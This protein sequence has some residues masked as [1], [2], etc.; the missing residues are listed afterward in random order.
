MSTSQITSA[1]I[2]IT[3]PNMTKNPSSRSKGHRWEVVIETLRFSI[4]DL[5][6]FTVVVA[7]AITV[8][9]LIQSFIPLYS[10]NV[11]FCVVC[12]YFIYWHLI[13]QFVFSLFIVSRRYSGNSIGTG[14]LVGSQNPTKR[15]TR[16]GLYV[17]ASIMV[18][19]SIVL[20]PLWTIATKLP[21]LVFLLNSAVMLFNSAYLSACLELKGKAPEDVEFFENGVCIGFL[22]FPW[23]EIDVQASDWVHPGVVI[24]KRVKVGKAKP[25]PVVAKVSLELLEEVLRIANLSQVQSVVVE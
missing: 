14:A 18:A 22:F 13:K 10:A 5:L 21:Q 8:G 19:F 9:R 7:L 24:Q 17:T 20:V 1:K 25:N 3:Q 11:F 6:K 12:G 23:E 15:G 16:N 2:Q 4:F